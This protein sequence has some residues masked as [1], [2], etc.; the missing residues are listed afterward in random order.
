MI[1]HYANKRSGW[2]VICG[3]Q[4]MHRKGFAP[5]QCSKQITSFSEFKLLSQYQSNNIKIIAKYIEDKSMKPAD[6]LL[7]KAFGL[8]HT[9]GCS[10]FTKT[11]C[12]PSRLQLQ[13]NAVEA[14]FLQMH[15]VISGNPGS[16]QEW[17]GRSKEVKGNSSI[18][19]R[20]FCKAHS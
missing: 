9:R 13:N 12:P 5:Q 11:P 14:F 10:I 4:D 7:A 18:K 3:E 19:Y 15:P 6:N 2:V 17:G 8:G 16:Q 20:L 1:Y